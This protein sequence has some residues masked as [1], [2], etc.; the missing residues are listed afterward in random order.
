MMF[1]CGKDACWVPVSS[2]VVKSNGFSSKGTGLVDGPGTHL[3]KP[4]LNKVVKN[5]K[6]K[7]KPDVKDITRP[8]LNS[9]PMR[10]NSRNS[11]E[12]SSSQR[13]NRNIRGVRFNNNGCV[14]CNERGH[15]AAECRHKH[16]GPV[17]CNT[18]GAP[19]HKS[20]HHEHQ[21]TSY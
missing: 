4:G 16:W 14:L 5:L 12:Q 2:P 8:F 9:R 6:L 1:E 10:G 7:I 20:K 13:P 21:Y 18:C 19:G 11:H 3:T 17:I 15:N